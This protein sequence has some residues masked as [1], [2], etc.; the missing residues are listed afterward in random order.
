MYYHSKFLVTT[1]NFTSVSYWHFGEL[2]YTLFT[3]NPYSSVYNH[4]WIGDFALKIS[5]PLFFCAL[6]I[7]KHYKW[8]TMQENFA[9]N[10]V[11]TENMGKAWQSHPERNIQSRYCKLMPSLVS[12]NNRR[13]KVRVH[14]NCIVHTMDSEKTCLGMKW[15]RQWKKSSQ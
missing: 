6:H 2:Q 9:K 4:D 10:P 8:R 11:T 5:W 7:T 13:K 14:N 15:R 1:L 3:S 12:I